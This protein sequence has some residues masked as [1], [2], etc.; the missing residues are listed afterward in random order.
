MPLHFLIIL[1]MPFIY[2]HMALIFLF[3]D[4]FVRVKMAHFR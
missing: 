2:S 1:F 3:R 4:D